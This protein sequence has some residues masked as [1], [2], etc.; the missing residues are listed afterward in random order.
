MPTWSKYGRKRRPNIFSAQRKGPCRVKRSDPVGIVTKPPSGVEKIW[1]PAG[2][3]GTQCT[4]WM[5][6]PGWKSS[7]TVKRRAKSESGP[8]STARRYVVVACCF[9]LFV[10][11]FRGGERVVRVGGRETKR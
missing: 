9:C 8:S 1:F 3:G 11:S 6:S 5:T 7:V 4:R 10:C 2:R